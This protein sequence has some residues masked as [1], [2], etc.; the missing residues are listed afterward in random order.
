[1][2]EHLALG[3]GQAQGAWRGRAERFPRGPGLS[4]SPAVRG[5]AKSRRDA[6]QSGEG[7][8]T[9]ERERPSG[10]GAGGR[11]PAGQAAMGAL[12]DLTWG[13]WRK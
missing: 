13:S 11:L 1:M 2:S 12:Q 4:M 8:G 9:S 6:M 10:T 5:Y 3:P 7:G